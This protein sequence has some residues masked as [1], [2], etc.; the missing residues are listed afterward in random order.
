VQRLADL[1]TGEVD[2]ELMRRED[3]TMRDIDINMAR[4]LSAM[5]GRLS[6]GG[7][8]QHYQVDQLFAA[9]RETQAR[10]H[11]FF[12]DIA[13]QAEGGGLDR[14]AFRCQ[15]RAYQ[16]DLEFL[17]D[18]LD[19]GFTQTLRLIGAALDEDETSL[20]SV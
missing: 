17:L 5:G 14:E 4:V 15:Y 13:A 19:D 9:K 11:A 2:I 7:G 6:E 1:L 3:S 10:T 20:S 18:R 16:R 12:Q 8:F